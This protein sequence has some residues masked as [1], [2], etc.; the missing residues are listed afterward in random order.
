MNQEISSGSVEWISEEMI[1]VG[2]S[3]LSGLVRK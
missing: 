2:Q 1:L 3:Q